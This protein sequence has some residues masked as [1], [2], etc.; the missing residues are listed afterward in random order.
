MHQKSC[1]WH[2]AFYGTQRDRLRLPEHGTPLLKDGFCIEKKIGRKTVFPG[3]FITLRAWFR[4]IASMIFP[5]SFLHFCSHLSVPLFVPYMGSHEWLTAEDRFNLPSGLGSVFLHTQTVSKKR[6]WNH[7]LRS[8]EE[9]KRHCGGH[10][11]KKGLLSE[12]GKTGQR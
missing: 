1:D 6:P 3:H 4:I 8:E 5:P 12:L 7:R 11:G 2:C 10:W 9:R